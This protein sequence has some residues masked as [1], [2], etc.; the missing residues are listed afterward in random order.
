MLIRVADL[1]RSGDAA[2][3]RI[4]A[5]LDAFGKT[6]DVEASVSAATGKD[7]RKEFAKVV[8]RFW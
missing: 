2:P 5:I 3:A 4:R 8:A 1:M 6:G 7:L